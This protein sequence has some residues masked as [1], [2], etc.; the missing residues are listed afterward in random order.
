MKNG[1]PRAAAPNGAGPANLHAA[2][3]G[4]Q[5]TPARTKH[6]S[7]RASLQSRR[8]RAA[9][10]RWLALAGR[11]DDNLARH[12][13]QRRRVHVVNVS[14]PILVDYMTHGVRSRVIWSELCSRLCINQN[15]TLLQF[16]PAVSVFDVLKIWSLPW[17]F[18]YVD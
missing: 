3:D 6:Q 2:G 14:K 16:G 9:A 15:Q 12:S 13:S 5:A 7:A 17:A 18:V 11:R 1:I 4:K 8:T 10:T